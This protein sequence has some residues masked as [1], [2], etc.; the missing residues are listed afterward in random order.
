MKDGAIAV[1]TSIYFELCCLIVDETCFPAHP[2]ERF[3]PNGEVT[4]KL[5]KVC[6]LLR[7]V[8]GKHHQSRAELGPRPTWVVRMVTG[9]ALGSGR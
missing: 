5:T 4:V 7:D 3:V 8:P 2:A 1:C 6:S 9:V